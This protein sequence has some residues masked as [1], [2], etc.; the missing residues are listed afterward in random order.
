MLEFIRR[1]ESSGNASENTESFDVAAFRLW[2]KDF[3]VDAF[4]I[5]C[6]VVTTEVKWQLEQ[7]I[8]W[9]IYLLMMCFYSWA[10]EWSFPLKKCFF[11][12]DPPAMACLISSLASVRLYPAV[13]CSKSFC[14]SRSTQSSGRQDCTGQYECA[15]RLKL[16]KDPQL[17]SSFFQL[18]FHVEQSRYRDS[19]CR[20]DQSKTAPGM[21]EL[22]KS[23]K[24]T[25]KSASGK[26]KI[27]RMTQSL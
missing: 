24:N 5:L 18:H 13:A 11:V 7:R 3:C 21:V 1:H 22:L 16:I 14:F 8:S 25:L 4:A 12:Q 27:Q 17:V 9:T 19:W 20:C 23:K 26:S 15:L 2:T 10:L 6:D